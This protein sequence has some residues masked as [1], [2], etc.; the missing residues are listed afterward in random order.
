MHRYCLW[1]RFLVIKLNTVHL[2]TGTPCVQNKPGK[3]DC[4][5]AELHFLP[6]QHTFMQ[7]KRELDF[8]LLIRQASKGFWNCVSV[9]RLVL[10]KPV[11][12]CENVEEIYIHPLH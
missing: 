12:L 5:V 8:M 4:F 10:I 11:S 6:S 7:Q 2:L 3:L 9:R 1:Y